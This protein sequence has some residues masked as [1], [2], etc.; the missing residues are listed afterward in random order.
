MSSINLAIIAMVLSGWV[1]GRPTEL[2]AESAQPDAPQ[3]A[4]SHIR[5]DI[6]SLLETPQPALFQRHLRSVL[7]LCEDSVLKLQFAGTDR[8]AQA[9]ELVG[10]LETIESGL[11]NQDVRRSETYLLEGRRSL[12]LLDCLAAMAR[13]SLTP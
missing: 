11:K 7:A 1:L 5:A 10:Y 12:D 8:D 4:L 3:V 6:K 2:C 9:K 13:Y